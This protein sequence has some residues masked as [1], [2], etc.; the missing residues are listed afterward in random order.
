MC[1]FRH[2]ERDDGK[3]LNSDPVKG[4]R[5]QRERIG[6]RKGRDSNILSLSLVLRNSAA[7]GIILAGTHLS[8]VIFLMT[9]TIAIVLMSPSVEEKMLEEIEFTRRYLGCDIFSAVHKNLEF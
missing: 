4:A 9:C 8:D 1:A 5:I 7:Q 3:R 2:D 6:L